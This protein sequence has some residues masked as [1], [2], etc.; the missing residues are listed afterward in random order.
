MF[1][2]AAVDAA[3]RGDQF[4]IAIAH[5]EEPTDAPARV[6]VDLVQAWRSKDG[7]PLAV[8][9]TVAEAAAIVRQYGAWQTFA[10]Q[11]SFDPL[12]EAFGRHGVYLFEAPWTATSKAPRFGMVRA[13]MTSGIVRLPDDAPLIRELHGIQGK[14]LAAARR[15]RPEAEG[16]TTG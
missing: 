7:T 3:F 13:A 2:F 1:Y 12:R 14:L 8:E 6:V 9:A 16:S 4:A 5:R 10:D 15:S 11:Y